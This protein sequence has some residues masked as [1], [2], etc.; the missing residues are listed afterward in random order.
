MY[1]QNQLLNIKLLQIFVIKRYEFNSK[2]QSFLYQLTMSH[3][4]VDPAS[5][6]QQNQHNHKR[7]EINDQINILRIQK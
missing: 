3:T 6:S 5:F 1:L 4:P 2:T 7:K